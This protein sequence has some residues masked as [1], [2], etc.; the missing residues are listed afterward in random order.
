MADSKSRCNGCGFRYDTRYGRIGCPV[1]DGQGL[2]TGPVVR[3]INKLEILIEAEPQ[4]GRK[5]TL[6]S[7]MK[8]LIRQQE[9]I[10][11]FTAK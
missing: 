7:C 10:N 6:T 5:A 9:A 8:E 11:A 1:C 2:D 4:R 3:L